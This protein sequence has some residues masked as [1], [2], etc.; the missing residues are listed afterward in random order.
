MQPVCGLKMGYRAQV[1]QLLKLEHL[2][3]LPCG[4]RV[5]P[6]TARNPGKEIFPRLFIAKN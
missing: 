5:N 3:V 2:I 4:T 1:C 6:G